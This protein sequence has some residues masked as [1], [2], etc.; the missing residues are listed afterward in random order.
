MNILQKSCRECDLCQNK[1]FHKTFFH[2]ILKEFC[3]SADFWPKWPPAC[4]L[5][6]LHTINSWDSPLS[7]WGPVIIDSDFR[8]GNICGSQIDIPFKSSRQN[9]KHNTFQLIQHNTQCS[10]SRSNAM[11]SQCMVLSKQSVF[12][13]TLLLF[14]VTNIMFL[15]KDI[16]L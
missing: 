13:Y 1:S 5:Y 3:I 8:L 7:Y 11:K 6:C 9:Y 2:N 10:I 12:V 15:S 16:L 14:F 4:V